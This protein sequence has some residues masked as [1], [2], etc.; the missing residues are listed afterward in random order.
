MLRHERVKQA[1]KREVSSIIVNELQDPRM[2]FVTITTVDLSPDMRYAKVLY[3]VM[4]NA[5]QHKKTKGALQSALGLIR[6]LVAERVKLRYAP[7]INFQEDLS[8]E[9]SVHMQEVFDKI[10]EL[11]GPEKHQHEG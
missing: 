9:Y 10:K 1:I 8:T 4:G 6:T 11:D 2:G 3:S 5:E 7:E